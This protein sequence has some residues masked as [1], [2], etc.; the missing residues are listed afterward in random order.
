MPHCFLLKMP[1]TML[2]NIQPSQRWPRR[3]NHFKLDNQPYDPGYINPSMG[4]LLMCPYIL[5][6]LAAQMADDNTTKKANSTVVSA[7]DEDMPTI[8]TAA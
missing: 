3:Y 8:M 1:T 4:L 5:S 2:V 7:A 6:T